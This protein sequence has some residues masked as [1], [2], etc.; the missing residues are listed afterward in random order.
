MYDLDTIKSCDHPMID[1]RTVAEQFNWFRSTIPDSQIRPTDTDSY[2][3]V[4][5]SY[6]AVRERILPSNMHCT[7]GTVL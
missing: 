4:K 6:N 7:H 5:I 3:F 1:P 2:T